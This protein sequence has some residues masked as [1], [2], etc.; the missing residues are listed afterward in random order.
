MDS[1]VAGA[2]ADL[3]PVDALVRPLDY[4]EVPSE[5][6]VD[7]AP[8]TGLWEI[9]SSPTLSVGVWEMTAGAMRDVEADEIFVVVDGEGTVTAFD[10][11]GGTRTVRLRPGSLCRLEAGT[12]TRWDVPERL[13]KVYIQGAPAQPA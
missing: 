5:Q 11:D 10:A 9:V 3:V 2:L 4:E 6:V 13:R 7:G 8:R 12:P 1:A